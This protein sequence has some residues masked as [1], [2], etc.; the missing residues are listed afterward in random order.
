MPEL[1]RKTAR[2]RRRRSSSIIVLG[3]RSNH[4]VLTHNPAVAAKVKERLDKFAK[5][6]EGQE[7]AAGDRRGRPAAA[8][9]ACRKLKAQQELRK[10][11]QKLV[12]GTIDAGRL[13]QGHATSILADMKL[14]RAD[15]VAYADKVMRG[16]RACVKDDY[17]KELNQG[18]LVG[19]AIRG[20]YRR[21]EEKMPPTTSRTSSTRSRT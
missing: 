21:L 16:H 1:A 17:V 14:K 10:D 4:F 11:Y 5:L 15:A 2:R 13:P 12:D 18:E 20:L 6:A 19:W 3:G 7:A 9:A 8:R